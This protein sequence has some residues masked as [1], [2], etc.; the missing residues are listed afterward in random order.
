[1]FEPVPRLRASVPFPNE[2]EPALAIGQPWGR[3]LSNHWRIEGSLRIAHRAPR[4]PHEA[5]REE[6]APRCRTTSTWRTRPCA[7]NAR[8]GE[9]GARSS[10]PP[11][12][13]RWS[14]RATRR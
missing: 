8:R 11:T 10:P 2:R 9:G 5:A 4:G 1:L 14:D 7:V 12:H 3:S 6:P 13:V